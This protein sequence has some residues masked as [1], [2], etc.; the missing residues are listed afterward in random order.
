M[1]DAAQMSETIVQVAFGVNA[2]VLLG[3]ML[4]CLGFGLVARSRLGV[5]GGLWIVT[6]LAIHLG[7]QLFHSDWNTQLIDRFLV[8]PAPA[9]WS[10]GRVIT[11][12]ALVSQG[13]YLFSL[14]TLLAATLAELIVKTQGKLDWG[15]GLFV[16]FLTAL[17]GF[18]GCALP[19]AL[20][21]SGIAGL[22]PGFIL[23]LLSD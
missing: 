16:S 1:N 22:G 7:L 4:L 23:L 19:A 20:L 18:R 6:A 10:L 5:T 3:I 15:E 11:L 17:N 2:A 13:L 8:D 9:D 12:V 14:L 21:I